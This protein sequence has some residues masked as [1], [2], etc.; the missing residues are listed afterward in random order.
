MPHLG[1]LVADEHGLLANNPADALARLEKA[2]ADHGLSPTSSIS[3]RCLTTAAALSA[4]FWC[5]LGLLIWLI[6]L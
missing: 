1:F 5:A 2:A 3:V 4:A 6:L